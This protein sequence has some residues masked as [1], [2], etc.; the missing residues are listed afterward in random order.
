MRKPEEREG[1]PMVEEED[2]WSGKG[3]E[4]HAWEPS[5]FYSIL[6]RKVIF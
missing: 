5:D 4:T 3:E 6:R 2:D 1:K